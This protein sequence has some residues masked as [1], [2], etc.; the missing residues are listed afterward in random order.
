MLSETVKYLAPL[1]VGV[2][3]PNGTEAIVNGLNRVLSHPWALSQDSTI[4]LVDF[5]NAFNRVNRHVFA[6][7]TRSLFPPS[8]AAW[9]HFSYGRSAI[10]FVRRGTISAQAG[11][12]QGDSLGPLFFAL[13]LQTPRW[14]DL[15]SY[16]PREPGVELLGAAV[17]TDLL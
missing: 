1:Q 8:L 6:E 13:A 7:A 14:L 2:G 5:D 16:A 12:Q 17:S 15:P 11:V 3:V 9:V 10:L 4:T